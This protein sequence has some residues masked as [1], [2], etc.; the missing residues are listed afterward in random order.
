VA[1]LIGVPLGIVA[2]YSGGTV[3]E[4]IM[5]VT[6]VFLSVAG[7]AWPSPWSARSAPAS[8]TR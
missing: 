7:A 6:D 3:G 4:L 8:S 5:R 1:A 2:G